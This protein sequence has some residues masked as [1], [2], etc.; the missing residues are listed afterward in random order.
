[1]IPAPKTPMNTGCPPTETGRLRDVADFIHARW[2]D[3]VR[4][5]PEDQGDLIG[6]PHPYTVPCGKDTFQELYYWDTYFTCVGLLHSGRREL[7]MANARNFLFLVG[8][9]GYVPNGS[10]THYLTRSQ[11]PY[12]GPLIRLLET[13]PEGKALAEEAR[14]ALEREYSFWIERRGTPTGLARHGNLAS[15][16]ELRQF[17]RD[18]VVRAQLIPGTDAQNLAQASHALSECES[19]WDFTPRFEHRC[20][21]F[22]PVDLNANLYLYEILLADLCPGERPAWLK[23][24]AR[25]RALFQEL[26]WDEER[27]AFYDYDFRNG[28]RSAVLGASAF[29]ALWAG[30]AT[31]R[32]AERMVRDA[33]PRL[34][35]PFGLAA[36]EARREPGRLCQWDYPNGWASVQYIAYRGLARYGY[37][38]EARRVAAKY[39]SV[40][41]NEFARTGDLWE[42]YNV[43]SAS[44]PNLEEEGWI[45]PAMMGWTAGV[46]LDALDFVHP[47][48]E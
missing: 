13:G 37:L 48:R 26:L 8:R 41:C 7:A 33:L 43:S 28:K 40:V 29:H 38:S 45:S 10:R 44:K 46:Y 1:M 30:L 17:F 6:L 12:L 9:Y 36:C 22:C 2:D 47:N 27:G 11:P 5:V 31:A 35:E 32:Q 16:E 20:E 19:G 39:L 15:P 4:H 24:A 23:R 18:I 25:R 21:D 14:P 42:K 3:T 34:E